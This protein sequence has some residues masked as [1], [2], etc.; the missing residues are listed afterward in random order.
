METMSA[1]DLGSIVHEMCSS[2][3]ISMQSNSSDDSRGFCST[4]V[5]ESIA[6]PSPTSMEGYFENI[7]T[8]SRA[9][10]TVSSDGG[11][12][13]YAALS[14]IWDNGEVVLRAMRV[15]VPE[16]ALEM[17]EITRYFLFVIIFMEAIAQKWDSHA[18]RAVT[19][20]GK[21]FKSALDQANDYAGMIR[22]VDSGYEFRNICFENLSAH[23]KTMDDT[24]TSLNSSD[25]RVECM[26]MLS[27]G[28]PGSSMDKWKFL[29]KSIET[30]NWRQKIPVL[31][32]ALS[33]KR[34]QR[35]IVRS[36]AEKA[37]EFIAKH[38]GGGSRISRLRS[39]FY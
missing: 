18:R 1:W 39:F 3:R 2:E 38:I 22:A 29:A 7:T 33:T 37:D 26:M 13:V 31:K 12:A 30:V 28:M 21:A 17:S 8:P 27:Q 34:T 10:V 14:E 5:P 9:P 19:R 6:P 35:R 32:W 4:I 11:E 24:I 20:A 23:N 16:N 36:C 25:Y 15:T